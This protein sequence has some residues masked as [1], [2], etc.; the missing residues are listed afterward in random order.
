MDEE[1][2]VTLDFT[3]RE[4]SVLQQLLHIATQAR[5]LDVAEAALFINRKLQAAAGTVQPTPAR[6]SNGGSLGVQK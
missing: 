2:K 1:P 5:G 6:Q 3:I 4:L